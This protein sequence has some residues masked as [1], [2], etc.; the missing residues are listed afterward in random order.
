MTSKDLVKIVSERV[1]T[2]NHIIAEGELAASPTM[3]ARRAELET[4]LER[5]ALEEIQEQDLDGR[6]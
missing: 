5:I 2:L 4:L 1:A 3:R 6:R